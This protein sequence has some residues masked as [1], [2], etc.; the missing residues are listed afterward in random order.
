MMYKVFDNGGSQVGP[1]FKT[2]KAAASYKII[3]GRNDWTVRLIDS[4]STHK[5]REAVRFC[6]QMLDIK[7]LG[8]INSFDQ[9]SNFLSMYLD[10]A[11]C[12]MCECLSVNDD[13]FY[14]K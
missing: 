1:S 14:D 10:H 3:Y 11:K 9:C 13:I 12:V 8:N 4:K 5:Q 7:F 2:Y 6:E